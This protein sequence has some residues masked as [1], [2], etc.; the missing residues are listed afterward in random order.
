[1]SLG[2]APQIDEDNFIGREAEIS[3]LGE[4][5]SHTPGKQKIVVLWG[6]GG[7]GKT[8]LSVHFAIRYQQEYSSIIWLNAQSETTLKAGLGSL[9]TR[10]SDDVDQEI[11]ADPRKDEDQAV[12]Y[13]RK[14]LSK[15]E[16]QN[17][18][19]IFDNY[20][21]PR[22]PGVESSTGYD[23]RNFFPHVVQGSVLITTRSNR[24]ALGK[25]IRLSKLS[26]LQQSLEILSKRSGRDLEGGNQTLIASKVFR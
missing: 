3:Q 10:I 13:A 16:N 23:I 20:D 17:W 6:L 4:W 18:L 24:V 11:V 5:L 19:L 9:A 21:D 25:L 26:S 1:L 22:L 14:W 8:Q 2:G 15:T 7:M 12:Q